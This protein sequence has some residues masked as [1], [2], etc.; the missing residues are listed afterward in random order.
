[1]S[2]INNN[3]LWPHLPKTITSPQPSQ[4][5][6]RYSITRIALAIL[7]TAA[8]AFILGQ[9]GRLHWTGNA[10]RSLFSSQ[11]GAPLSQPF[12]L[13]RPPEISCDT[14]S[15]SINIFTSYTQDN[16]ER[17]ELSRKVM[18]HQSQYCNRHGYNYA[19][20]EQN[21]AE[22]G[23]DKSL[24]YWSKI[25]GINRILSTTSDDWI[26]WMDDDAVIRNGD[27]RMEKF[28]CDH[29]GN[30]PKIHIIVT[31]DVPHAG[32]AV[33][34]G[35][36]IVRN[37]EKSRAFFKELW[38]MRH[39]KIFKNGQFTT[40]SQCPAQSCLHEQEAM[41]DL[42]KAHP[43]YLEFVK[44]IPQTDEHG[45]GINTFKRFNHF[46]FNRKDFW[47]NPMHLIYSNDPLKSTCKPTDFICQCT[48]L[49][50]NGKRELSDP[51]S[52]LRME[53]I[54]ELLQQAK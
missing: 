48:G 8:A 47:G 6:C 27:I 11:P 50:T 33:N 35:V 31:S 9:S 21:L 45:V 36:L 22:S 52:N 3:W 24:P 13:L 10:V 5:K 2:S 38:E 37:S 4:K 51:L 32:T 20:Y 23:S 40:Y 49:A 30:D 39:K 17:L 12:P 14:N 41:H 1:M 54:E 25:A 15:Q 42:L 46:D 26:I 16:P 28:I 18:Q 19:V 34:T 44:I 43:E 53:C 7:G 29:G